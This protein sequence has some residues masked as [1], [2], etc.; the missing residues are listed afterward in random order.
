[1]KHALILTLSAFIFLSG[2]LAAQ[3]SDTDKRNNARQAALILMETLKDNNAKRVVMAGIQSGYYADEA[4]LF[5][6]LFNP[7][8]SPAYRNN[9]YLGSVPAGSFAAVFRKI[10]LSKQYY[11]S[12]A[13]PYNANLEQALISSKA[14]VY[15]PYSGNFNL[16]QALNFSVTFDPVNAEANSNGGWKYDGRT[17]GE[18]LVDEPYVQSTP[19]LIANFYEGNPDLPSGIGMGE[20]GAP[21]PGVAGNGVQ[22]C[23]QPP[24]R[25]AVYVEDFRFDSQWDNLFAGGPEFVFCRGELVYN[26]DGTQVSGAPVSVTARFKR[27][28]KGEWVNVNIL[29][30]SRWEF[31]NDQ[32]EEN[33]QQFAIYEDDES[34]NTSTTLTGSVGGTV[35]IPKF[36]DFNYNVSPSITHN[37]TADDDVVINTQ[38]DRCWFITSN[39]Q[40]QGFGL[41]N[42]KAIRGVGGPGAVLFNMR[43]N[44]Y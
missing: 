37:T 30:D 24:L 9:Q 10:L 26:G 5:R 36:G 44:E 1:M 14:Q 40:S 31:I 19:T 21:T 18:V 11:L 8:A 28:N 32:F 38:F 34:S 6:D 39:T 12:N 7:Q 27:K 20:G 3:G 16:N 13:S 2:A 23:D 43:I 33:N 15:F 22:A 4:I 17:Y 42:N 29:W 41:R 35:A 25:M